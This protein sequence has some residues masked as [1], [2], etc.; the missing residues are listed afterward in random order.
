ML[1]RKKAAAVVATETPASLVSTED[2]TGAVALE[3]PI[4]RV[5]ANTA[6]EDILLGKSTPKPLNK[7]AKKVICTVLSHI[8]PNIDVGGQQ[9]EKTGRW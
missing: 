7:K 6:P 4:K 9:G 3:Q 2:V 5:R 8:K 1:T